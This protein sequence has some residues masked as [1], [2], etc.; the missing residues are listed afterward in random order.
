MHFRRYVKNVSIDL[1]TEY[2][3]FE[4]YI[5]YMVILSYIQT[6]ERYC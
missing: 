3:E 6:K 4:N 5:K 1:L 2:G